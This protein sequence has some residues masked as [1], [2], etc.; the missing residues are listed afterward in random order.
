MTNKILAQ[1]EDITIKCSVEKLDSLDIQFIDDYLNPETE[2][3]INEECLL[4]F[5]TYPS[6]H[7]NTNNIKS[8]IDILNKRLSFMQQIQMKKL[9]TK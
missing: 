4:Q 3:N 9:I 2:S 5:A 8:L 6:V 1:P 7:L